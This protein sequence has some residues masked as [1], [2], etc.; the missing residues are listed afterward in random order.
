L[1]E[2][3]ALFDRLK[4]WKTYIVLGARDESLSAFARAIADRLR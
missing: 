1:Q 4:E 3:S 2:R